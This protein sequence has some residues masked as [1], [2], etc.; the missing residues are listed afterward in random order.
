[1]PLGHT[2]YLSLDA[3]SE[4]VPLYSS[5]VSSY[6]WL[7]K[8]HEYAGVAASALSQGSILR[9]SISA[10]NFSD[11]FLSLNYIWPQFHPKTTYT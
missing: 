2:V 4:M 1:M 6:K 10:E 9:N 11:K 7:D 5:L 3:A 8:A